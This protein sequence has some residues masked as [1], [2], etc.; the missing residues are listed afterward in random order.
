MLFY[1]IAKLIANYN[2]FYSIVDNNNWFELLKKKYLFKNYLTREIGDER[3]INFHINAGH[4][5][6]FRFYNS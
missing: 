5:K 6:T 3:K 4:D 2:T 1:L